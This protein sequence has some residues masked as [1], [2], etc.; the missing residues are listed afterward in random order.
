[1][2]HN[3]AHIELNAI[4][5]AWDTVARFSHLQLPP[6]FYEDFARVAD[7]ESR[8]FGWCLQ[9]LHELGWTYG[10]MVAH[11]L[12]WQGAQASAHD[13]NA[14]WV[15]GQGRRGWAISHAVV[16]GSRQVRGVALEQCQSHGF[17][18]PPSPA[19]ATHPLCRLV[20]VPTSQEAV[21]K[22]FVM[23]SFFCRLAIVP[24]S[25]EARGLDAGQRLVERLVGAGDPRSAGIVRQIAVEEKAHVAVGECVLCCCWL[26]DVSL[27]LSDAWGALHVCD[28]GFRQCWLLRRGL[29][30]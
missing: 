7:D 17:D 10:D 16:V 20:V 18:K 24:M 12:L 28:C 5:L 8:H 19:Y 11:D 9:R 30:V 6:G 15:P 14:R 27:L 4:D 3:L 23:P 21:L 2:L 29:E 1:M 13:L 22:L 25:Q 26:E